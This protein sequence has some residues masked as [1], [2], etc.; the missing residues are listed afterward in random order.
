M[1]EQQ[2]REHAALMRLRREQTTWQIRELV[3]RLSATSH[4]GTTPEMAMALKDA[5]ER[6]GDLLPPAHSA[7]SPTRPGRSAA[8]ADAQLERTYEPV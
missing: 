6:I 1:T 3:M 7:A 2:Y 5:M 8:R 4:Y